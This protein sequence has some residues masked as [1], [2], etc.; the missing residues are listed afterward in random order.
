MR[1]GA[2]ESPAR[3]PPIT[4]SIS[5]T[6]AQAR[7]EAGDSVYFRVVVG[8]ESATQFNQFTSHNRSGTVTFRLNNASGPVIDTFTFN[9]SFSDTYNSNPGGGGPIVDV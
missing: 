9:G 7:T 2:V 5:A 4:T 3:R 1:R 8:G 6:A